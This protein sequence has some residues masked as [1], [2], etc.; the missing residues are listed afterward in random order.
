MTRKRL[1]GYDAYFQSMNALGDFS[2]LT[3]KA[4]KQIVPLV[5]RE[6]RRKEN[7]NMAFP[8]PIVDHH[9]LSIFRTA[10]LVWTREKD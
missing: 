9:A 1:H 8:I 7:L 3:R 6:M 4:T 2:E 5:S 10:P